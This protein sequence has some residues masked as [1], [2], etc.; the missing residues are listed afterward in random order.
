[1][2]ADALF[3]DTSYLVRLYL[4]DHG[5]EAVREL[6]SISRVAATARLAQ[7]EVVGALHR[8]FRER[9]ME[10][11]TF[12]AAVDQFVHDVKAG[13]FQWLPLTDG[14]QRRL[15]RVFRDA[16]AAVFLRGADALHL[17][18]AAEHGFT[19]A[20]SNDRHFLAAAS[21]FGLRG[22]NVIA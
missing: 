16:P 1:M 13:L 12:Q 20:H 2:P 21:L 18:C 17:A 9:G 8:A 19:E 14:V 5:F 15:E 11:H 3:F 4:E 7:A 6:A 22:V 10:K